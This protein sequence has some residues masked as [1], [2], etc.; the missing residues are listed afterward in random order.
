LRDRTG[1]AEGVGRASSSFCEEFLNLG[2]AFKIDQTGAYD[3]IP[4]DGAEHAA[5]GGVPLA[6]RDGDVTGDLHITRH[7]DELHFSLFSR[8]VTRRP[9]AHDQGFREQLT[10]SAQL[11]VPI[12]F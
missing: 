11:I 8:Q 1:G 3:V 6:I 10:H 2:L 7:R 12:K 4:W 5:D 9:N